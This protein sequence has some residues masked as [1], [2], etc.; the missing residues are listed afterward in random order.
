MTLDEGL[1]KW[2]QQ[3][4]EKESEGVVMIMGRG[5]E[6]GPG[7]KKDEWGIMKRW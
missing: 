7:G 4:E 1:V 3:I 6:V 5:I 2:E